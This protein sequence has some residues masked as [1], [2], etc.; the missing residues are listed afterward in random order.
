[1]KY[2]KSRHNSHHGMAQQLYIR[3]H[4]LPHRML[5]CMSAVSLAQGLIVSWDLSV[6]GLVVRPIMGQW[7]EKWKG[8]SFSFSFLLEGW[9]V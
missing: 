8:V 3:E 9:K 4:F 2:S 5:F 1:M 7:K 6:M